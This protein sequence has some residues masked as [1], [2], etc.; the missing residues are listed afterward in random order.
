MGLPL[1]WNIPR[2]ALC[3]TLD[4]YNFN[5]NFSDFCQP[6]TS[7]AFAKTHKTGSTTLQ[8]IIL[9]QAYSRDLTVAVPTKGWVF[10][11]KVPFN[12]TN[13]VKHYPWNP[14][15]K[16]DIFASHSVWN[17]KEVKTLVGIH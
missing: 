17:T 14:H 7:L 12:A 9:R 4:T 15:H 8:N 11:L 6:K 2:S 16:F 5:F 10:N 3:A 13:L 1:R